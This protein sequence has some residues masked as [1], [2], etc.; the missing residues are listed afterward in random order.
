MALLTT[1]EVAAQV[2]HDL[3]D[4]TISSLIE[5]AEEAIIGRFG[6][7]ASQVDYNPP[8]T[9]E[10]FLF[11]RRRIDTAS[12]TTIVETDSGDEDTTLA[13]DDFAIKDNGRIVKRLANGTNGSSTWAKEVTITYVP[14]DETGMRKQIAISLIKLAISYNAHSS[15]SIGKYSSSSPSYQAERESILSGLKPHKR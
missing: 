5:D 2:E 14:I 3:S 12:A 8:G 1:G 10:V 7:L 11:P 13:S 15:E 4:T 9:G 6:E